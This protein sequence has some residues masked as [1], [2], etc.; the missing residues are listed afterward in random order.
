MINVLMMQMVCITIATPVIDWSGPVLNVV[1]TPNK[2]KN[3]ISIMNSSET[4][5]KFR[6]RFDPSL[7]SYIHSCVN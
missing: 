5:G 4:R 6:I 3:F 1:A 7:H 2:L